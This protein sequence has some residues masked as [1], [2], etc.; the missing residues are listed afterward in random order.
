MSPATLAKLERRKQIAERYLR[1]DRQWEIARAFGISQATVSRELNS[2]REEW[3]AAADVAIGQVVARELAKIELLEAMY[4]TAWERSCEQRAIDTVKQIKNS[5]AHG[6]KGKATRDEASKRLE[7]RDGD[8]RYL[9]GI[10]RCIRLRAEIVGIIKNRQEVTGPDASAI[11]I[12]ASATVIV[13]EDAAWF[14][15]R[16]SLPPP[17]ND[18][19]ATSTPPPSPA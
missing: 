3:T 2:L 5:D 7:S 14:G 16:P 4:W 1:L 18:A 9:A 6:T 13:V 12:A 11:P 8:P 17:T 15:T 10:E 19:P